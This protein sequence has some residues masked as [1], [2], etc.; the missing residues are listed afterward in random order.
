MQPPPLSHAG[1]F[2]LLE[3]ERTVTVTRE[4][5]HQDVLAGRS[6]STIAELRSCTITA[7]K[8][9]GQDGL[10]VLLDGRRVGELTR[11]M[12][13]RYRP[14]V[15]E[16]RA[17]GNRA[18]CEAV[19]RDDTRGVQVELRLP[20]ATERS[21]TEP[22]TAPL[23]IPVRGGAS[24]WP[25]RPVAGGSHPV[26]R[27]R[28]RSP[29]SPQALPGTPAPYGVPTP[30]TTSRR[31]SRRLLGVTGAVVGVLVLASALG[32]GSRDEVPAGNSSALPSA[33][34]APAVPA[35]VE[36]SPETPV[37]VPAEPAARSTPQARPPAPATAKPATS[38][39]T[40]PKPTTP[41]PAPRAVQAAPAPEPEPKS[42]PKSSGCDSN[43]DGCVPI[44]TDVDCEGGSGNGPAYVSG[45]VRVI[46]TDKYGLDNNQD[47]IGCE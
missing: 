36:P 45:P 18:G 38:K 29:G 2:V 47:G 20:A 30:P 6:G 9:A 21:A 19:L 7:G 17:R 31:R 1:E 13:Q 32:N 46:G 23:M 40:T 11:L 25:G 3:G 12:A 41:R 22:P 4:E 42:E 44:A 27:Q 24:R 26:P 15:D 14:M 39:P 28:R 34:A 10:E 35:A 33:A 16:I 43:Y 37:A 5:H 8:H